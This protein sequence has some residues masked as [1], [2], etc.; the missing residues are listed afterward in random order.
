MSLQFY[1]QVSSLLLTFRS[2]NSL[3][4]PWNHW[5]VLHPSL[6]SY[7]FVFQKV[8]FIEL[9]RLSSFEPG[10][11]PFAWFLWEH[12][13]YWACHWL[14]PVY[15]LLRREGQSVFVLS[16]LNDTWVPVVFVLCL[17][18]LPFPFS[19]LGFA[20]SIPKPDF[21]FSFCVFLLHNC[22]PWALHLDSH[23]EKEHEG[24]VPRP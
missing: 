9:H 22:L 16:L 4:H 1:P 17:L 5:S 13:C 14:V 2:Q 23:S 7:P 20:Y 21:L 3:S 12:W 24:S 6:Q 10:F 8:T 18:D 15:Y 11:L 19:F